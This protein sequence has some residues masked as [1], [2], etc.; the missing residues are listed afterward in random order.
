[1][2]RSSSQ[3]ESG[4]CMIKPS[5][6][7]TTPEGSF[8]DPNK[9]IFREETPK[10]TQAFNQIQEQFVH[11]KSPITPRTRIKRSE[12]LETQYKHQKGGTFLLGNEIP[13][14]TAVCPGIKIG[15]CCNF[16][17]ALSHPKRKTP[18]KRRIKV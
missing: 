3:E 1:M 9:G 5:C 15:F 10:K 14:P 12:N 17:I 16:G 8:Y 18:R 13:Q 4:N 11:P 7:I 2:T 6:Q